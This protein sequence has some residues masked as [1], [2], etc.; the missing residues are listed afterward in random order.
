VA[1]A[2]REHAAEVKGRHV[3][4]FTLLTHPAKSKP[5]DFRAAAWH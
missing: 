1:R 3:I 5:K 2:V 4:A